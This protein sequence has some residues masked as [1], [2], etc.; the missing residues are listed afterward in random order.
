MRRL[1][2][3]WAGL[4][5]VLIPTVFAQFDSPFEVSAKVDGD[6]AVVTATI[7][8]GHY[9]YVGEF[10]V[11]DAAG[12]ALEPLELP[13]QDS[14]LDPFSGDRKPAYSASFVARYEWTPSAAGAGAVKVD[15][16]GCN[17]ETCFIPQSKAF[18]V[19]ETA[20]NLAAPVELVELEVEDG[21]A[22]WKK[23]IEFFEVAGSG[24]G[25]MA[26]ADFL[27]FLAEAENG[28]S[29]RSELTGF[30]LFLRDPVAFVRESGVVLTVIFI[31]LGGLMLNLTP[32]VLP[33]IPIN[34]AIIG[35]GAQASSRKR[36]FALGAVYGAGIAL[37]YGLVGLIVVKTGSSFGTIQSNP[38]FNLVIALVFVALA[39]AMFDLFHID[40]SRF[41]NKLGGN[42]GKQGS[43]WLALSMGAVAALLAGACVAPVVIAVLLLATSLG[44]F[45]LILPFVLGFGMAL[46]WPFAGAGLSFLPK[47]GKWM[48]YVKYGFGVGIILFALYYA[49]LS[50]HG[51]R[52]A[53]MVAGNGDFAEQLKEARLAGKPVLIDFWAEWCKN[54]H[55]M[56]KTTFKDGQV[57]EKLKGYQFIKYQ[58][59]DPNDPETKAVME[60]FVVQGLPT[61]VILTPTN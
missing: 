24:A 51:F 54:C 16:M 59:E 58:A 13:K 25:Y 37:V 44:T 10:K 3:V 36:G 14:V 26:A 56:D 20:A 38:W 39:L 1:F 57:Q 7:P 31:L 35:A 19:A 6:V 52:P 5:I 22:G 30:R 34:L 11:A 15:Y 43:Y 18:P 2:V 49:N 33:M 61:Y 28:G 45:G 12:V 4:M 29:E 27:A 32:C 42:T 53:S 40:L 41:Q 8:E 47:P 50:Y 48:E 60:H 46:P 23:E 9:L 17:H 21:S 55:A